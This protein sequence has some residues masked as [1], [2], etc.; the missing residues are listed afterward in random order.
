MKYRNFFNY[1]SSD[2]D[3]VLTVIITSDQGFP[4]EPTNV[5][6]ILSKSALNVIVEI[7]GA[8]T[9]QLK[10]KEYKKFRRKVKIMIINKFDQVDDEINFKK[11]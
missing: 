10:S 2:F 3:R 7:Q 5:M 1:E 9:I 4:K 6:K 8:E 11:I